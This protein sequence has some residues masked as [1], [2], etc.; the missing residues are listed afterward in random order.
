MYIMQLFHLSIVIN[1]QDP[2]MLKQTN[3]IKNKHKGIIFLYYSTK[4]GIYKEHCGLDK[5][6]LSWGHDEYLYRVL[7]NHGA[8]IP[9][10]GL[11]MIRQGLLLTAGQCS[12]TK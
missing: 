12:S 2:F 11:A 9:P 3:K 4:L 6:T 10:E 1:L 8:T 7:I 5:V